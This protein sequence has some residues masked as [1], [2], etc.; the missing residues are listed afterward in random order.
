MTFEE[1]FIKK[2]IDLERL[3]NAEPALFE[4]FRYDYA[5]MGEKSFDHTKKFWFNRLRK[6]YHLTPVISPDAQ[7]PAKSQLATQA[8]PLS[9]PTIV[10]KPLYSPRFKPRIAS[11]PKPE[12]TPEKAAKDSLAASE[13]PVLDEGFSPKP[14]DT[15]ALSVSEDAAASEAPKP[16]YKPRFKAAAMKKEADQPAESTPAEEGQSN[17]SPPPAKP[18]YKP[19]FQPGMVKKAVPEGESPAQTDEEQAGVPSP[20]GQETDKPAYK[21]RFKAGIVK[22][23]GDRT[24]KNQT[25][26]QT[27]DALQKPSVEPP[28]KPAYKPRFKPGMTGKP[29]PDDDSADKQE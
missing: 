18:A 16:A 8:E 25:E 17:Q 28:A 26:E 22:N 15:Q 29:K 13:H 3:K 1:F 20:A 4:E 27:P 21:P 7:K 5:Q 12:D 6:I 23:D 2:K 14:P 24:D 11:Q 9:S 10:E 19:R